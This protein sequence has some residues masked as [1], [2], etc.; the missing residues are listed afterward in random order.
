[1]KFSK[2]INGT[3]IG[4]YRIDIFVDIPQN[5]AGLPGYTY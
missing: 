4:I 2:S 5:K 1:M 3:Q